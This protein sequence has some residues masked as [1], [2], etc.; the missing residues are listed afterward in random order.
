MHIRHLG[1]LNLLGF[2]FV[3]EHEEVPIR[4]GEEQRISEIRQ[5]SFIFGYC[6]NSEIREIRN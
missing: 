3:F 2:A 5:I 4:H 6:K 1:T